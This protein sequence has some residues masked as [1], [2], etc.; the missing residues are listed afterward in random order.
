M[1][2][3]KSLLIGLFCLVA[4]LPIVYT[5]NVYAEE[6]YTSETIYT[7][8]SYGTWNRVSFSDEG[9]SSY[10]HYTSDVTFS[11]T[12]IDLSKY[13]QIAISCA[14]A[15]YGDGS[16]TIS[17]NV[18]EL[19]D[20]TSVTRT[21]GTCTTNNTIV[22]DVSQ[23]TGLAYISGSG[24]AHWYYKNQSGTRV[25][26]RYYYQTVSVVGYIPLSPQFNPNSYVQSNG[27]LT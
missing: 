27:N 10:A 16:A 18:T 14:R 25:Y 21:L 15:G 5:N 9:S 24:S 1:K 17:L 7:A 6:K 2:R 4:T 13:S 3:L 12:G 19:K 23:E 22:I 11:K 20:G 8:N 26:D